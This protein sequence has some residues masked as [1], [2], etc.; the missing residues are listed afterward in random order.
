MT[1]ASAG[2]DELE[3]RSAE[4]AE[5]GDWSALRR[6]LHGQDRQA[7]LARRSLS[8]LYGRSL[9]QTGRMEEL[10]AFADEFERAARARSD[11]GGVMAALNFAG[12]A[13][14]ER[15]ETADARRRYESLLTLAEGESDDRMLARATNNLGMVA[16][17]RGR[18]AEALRNYRLAHPLFQKLADEQG[19]AQLHHNLG[20][21]HRDLGRHDDAVDAFRRAEE[22]ADRSGHPYLAAMALAGRAEVV[23]EREDAPLACELARRG[24]ERARRADDPITEAEARRVLAL[25]RRRAGEATVEE[26]LRELE[27][28]GDLARRHGHALLAAETARDAGLLLR[29][30]GRTSDARERLEAARAAFRELGAELYTRGVEEELQELESG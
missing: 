17:L 21:S 13:A 30:S 18:C 29:E 27:A 19:L 3:R 6:Y 20:I 7:V 16:Q 25:A 28:A 24:L 8:Y 15:G 9:Y 12:T 2:R 5:T 1:A 26:V 4:L 14:F 22:L 11:V 10:A 23:L